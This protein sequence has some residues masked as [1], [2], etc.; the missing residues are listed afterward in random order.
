MGMRLGMGMVITILTHPTLHPYPSTYPRISIPPYP[1]PNLIKKCPRKM[2]SM[3]MGMGM[4]MGLGMN[5]GMGT[6]MARV[7]VRVWAWVSMGMSM[8]AGE[9]WVRGIHMGV[10]M[11]LY[12]CSGEREGVANGGG[13]KKTMTDRGWGRGAKTRLSSG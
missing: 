4:S 2:M 8:G 6:G 11:P 9:G 1:Y 10:T 3:G 5:M 7:W 13:T 12:P